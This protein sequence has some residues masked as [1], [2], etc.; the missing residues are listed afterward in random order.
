MP[1]K[2]YPGKKEYLIKYLFSFDLKEIIL[3]KNIYFI[4][5]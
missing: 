2:E 4:K 5:I 1:I 3:G